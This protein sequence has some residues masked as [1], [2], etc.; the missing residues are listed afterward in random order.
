MG[1][2]N[3]LTWG[4]VSPLSPMSPGGP[5]GPLIKHI[6]SKPHIIIMLTYLSSVET[7]RADNSLR[8]L[9]TLKYLICQVQTGNT[10]HI[11]TYTHMYTHTCT[12]IYTNTNVY[13]YTNT[14]RIMQIVHGGK[15]LRFSRISLQ[16]QRFSSE[17][18]FF[19]SYKVFQIAVQSR[20]FSHE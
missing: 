18:F 11:H 20:K 2:T 17:F 19:I 7:H 13:T 10:Q 9:L 4:P 15:L 14:Y 1:V 5:G 16:S 3:L 8:A 6:I 12:N